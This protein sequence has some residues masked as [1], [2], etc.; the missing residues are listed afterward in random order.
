MRTHTTMA[1]RLKIG[2]GI[3]TMNFNNYTIKAQEIVQKAIEIAR[4]NQNQ[5]LE[6]A[7]LMKALL[8]EGES[9]VKFIFQKLDIAPAMIERPLEEELARLPLLER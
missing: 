9:V 4:R 2:D 7:H 8:T 5:A 6:P 3:I 1:L